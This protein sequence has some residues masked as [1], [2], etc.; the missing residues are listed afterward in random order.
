MEGLSVEQPKAHRPAEGLSMVQN[1][2]K[3]LKTLEIKHAMWYNSGMEKLQISETSTAEMVTISRAEYESMKAQNAE[4]S[5]QVNWLM[6]QIRLARQK[7]LGLLPSRKVRHRR[8]A[9][10]AV[11]RG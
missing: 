8:A 2:T 3:A 11:Q 6:E 4:L 5:Q 9:E 7:R 1:T 10:L